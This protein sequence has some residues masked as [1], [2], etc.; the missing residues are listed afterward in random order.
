MTG[1]QSCT[2]YTSPAQD[3]YCQHSD[4]GLK[5]LYFHTKNIKGVNSTSIRVQDNEIYSNAVQAWMDHNFCS[6]RTKS[7]KTQQSGDTAYYISHSPNTYYPGGQRRA[8]LLQ[9]TAELGINNR[10][11]ELNIPFCGASAL[12]QQDQH[13]ENR[14][15]SSWKTGLREATTTGFAMQTKASRRAGTV[16]SPGS[17]AYTSARHPSNLHS[18]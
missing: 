13:A 3:A 6:P 17:H 1:L 18:Q 11:I 12:V 9:V 15:Y 7:P 4:N 14:G 5:L 2:I 10:T 16:I 8:G